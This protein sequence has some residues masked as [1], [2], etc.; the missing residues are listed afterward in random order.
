MQD[1]LALKVHYRFEGVEGGLW[2]PGRPQA[3]QR[4][5]EVLPGRGEALNVGAIGGTPGMDRDCP[6]K[7]RDHQNNAEG[8]AWLNGN[9]GAGIL[10]DYV[11]TLKLR[12]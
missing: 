10:Q 9:R 7:R 3:Q 8:A 6:A 5:E 2:M 4:M 11:S 1:Q 12:L